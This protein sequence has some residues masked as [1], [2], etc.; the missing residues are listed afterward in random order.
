M[1]H[2]AIIS[3]D[4]DPKYNHCAAAPQDEEGHVRRVETGIELLRLPR[5]TG[6]SRLQ[7]LDNPDEVYS[8]LDAVRL[9]QAPRAWLG[10]HAEPRRGQVGLGLGLDEPGQPGRPAQQ[11]HQEPGG[12]RIE[13]AGMPAAR[14]RSARRTRCTTSC[15]VSPAGLS[16]STAPISPRLPAESPPAAR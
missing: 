12:E 16:T 9:P 14:I 1:A 6:R 7:P 3:F 5:R 15:E 11:D 2:V 4:I 13:R 10:R 8:F